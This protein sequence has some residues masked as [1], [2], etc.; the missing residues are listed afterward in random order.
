MNE[1]NG[2][3]VFDEQTKK[4]NRRAVSGLVILFIVPV[5]LAYVAY[6][7]GWFTQATRN[8]GTLLESPYP[9]FEQFSWLDAQGEP[10]HFKEFETQ[11]WWIYLPE[12]NLCD[13]KC[14]LNLEFL[15]RSHQGLAKRIEKLTIM[16]IFPDDIQ[17]GERVKNTEQLRLAKGTGQ[18]HIGEGAN[19]E[20]GKI[21]AMDVHGNIFMKY[22]AVKTQDE[23]MQQSKALRDDI[24]RVMRN[25]GL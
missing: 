17:Y 24:V 16:M 18:P 15:T 20:S 8:N 22:D 5:V 12:S 6:Y 9:R 4:Q 13:A 25:T 10:L 1:D 3:V 23:A 21:Y 11:W 7:Q 14:E 19:L 2:K